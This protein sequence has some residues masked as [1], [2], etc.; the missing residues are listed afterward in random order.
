MPSSKFILQKTCEICGKQFN[1]KTVY[2]KF[3]SKKCS[4]AEYRKKKAQEKQEEKRK[5]LAERIPAERP[6]ISITEAVALYGISRDTIYRQIR[7]GNIPAVN[8]GERLN[9]INKAN[10]EL[11][12]PPVNSSN[13]ASMKEQPQKLIYDQSECYTIGEISEKYGISPSTVNKAIRKNSIPRKQI[14]KFVYV[15]KAE[16][17]QLFDNK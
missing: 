4:N 1:A 14:G 2:S 8:L 13:I 3:C 7:K 11:M 17:D 12:F 10:I 6:Y 9:R 16:I 15:P 5:Q